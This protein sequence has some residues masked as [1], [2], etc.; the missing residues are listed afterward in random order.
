MWLVD[1]LGGCPRGG[2]RLPLRRW[3]RRRQGWRP[4]SECHS[5]RRRP[6][7]PA[8]P[9]RNLFCVLLSIEAAFVAR[10]I[11]HGCLLQTH[12]T[13]PVSINTALP[14]PRR[15]DGFCTSRGNLV[16][17]NA[18]ANEHSPALPTCNELGVLNRHLNCRLV[19]DWCY[20]WYYNTQHLLTD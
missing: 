8:P 15:G 13:G 17:L 16:V 7:K 20:R 2:R 9:L 6:A 10:A 18:P 19:T 11:V 1:S 14:R 12:P 5:P 4:A 3:R